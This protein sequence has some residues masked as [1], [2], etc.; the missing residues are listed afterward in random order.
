MDTRNQLF[1]DDFVMVMDEQYSE[2]YYGIIRQ[3]HPGYI[4]LWIGYTENFEDKMTFVSIDD[5]HYS[6]A[7]LRLKWYRNFSKYRFNILPRSVE[8]GPLSH[9]ILSCGISKLSVEDI[10]RR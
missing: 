8:V 2:G 6:V 9:F 10:S 1:I 7:N 3:I 4:C 5:G